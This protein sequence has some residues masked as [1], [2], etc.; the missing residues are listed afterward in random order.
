MYLK[1]NYLFWNMDMET[2][3]ARYEGLCILVVINIL[4]SGPM[5]LW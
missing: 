5:D 3:H 1:Y 4:S 2:E